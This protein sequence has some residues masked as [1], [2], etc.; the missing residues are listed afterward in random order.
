MIALA[1]IVTVV[2]A[3]LLLRVGASAEFSDAGLRVSVRVGFVKI[4]VLPKKERGKT[5]ESAQKSRKKRE[6]SPGSAY[7]FHALISG[8]VKLLNKLRRKILIK[9]L[10][11]RYVQGG[12]DAF[13]MAMT[14][15]GVAAVFGVSQGV[16]ETCFRVKSYLLQTSVDYLAAEP[17]IYA[18]AALSLAVWEVISIGI[19]AIIVFIKAKKPAVTAAKGEI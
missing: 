18:E 12:G 14:H 9:R 13:T 5:L 11:V 3:L 15:G 4:A 8:A 19:S 16:L 17:R 10:S 7:D 6:K 2:A 1:I